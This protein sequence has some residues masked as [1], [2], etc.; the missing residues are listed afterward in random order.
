[1]IIPGL[2]GF[3][4]LTQWGGMYTDGWCS[5]TLNLVPVDPNAPPLRPE[6]AEELLQSPTTRIVYSAPMH[7]VNMCYAWAQSWCGMLRGPNRERR[8]VSAKPFYRGEYPFGELN[9]CESTRIEPPW[10]YQK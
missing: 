5:V 3:Q 2:L 1:M 7:S 4:S 8:V 10:Y 6:E 9:T